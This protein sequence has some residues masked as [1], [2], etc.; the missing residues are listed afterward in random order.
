M[1]CGECETICELADGEPPTPEALGEATYLANCAGCHGNPPGTGFAPDL[2]GE[3]ASSILQKFESG[4][5][6][7]GAFPDLALEDL[8]NLEAYFASI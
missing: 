7:G 6:A 8:D 5:H 2:T 4:N 1:L 3:S